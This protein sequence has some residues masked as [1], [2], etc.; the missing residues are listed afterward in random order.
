MDHPGQ[1][2]LGDASALIARALVELAEEREDVREALGVVLRWSQGRQPEGETGVPIQP[3]GEAQALVDKVI[4]PSAPP[5][6]SPLERREPPASVRQQRKVSLETIVRRAGWKAAAC[7]LAVDR[8]RT[9]GSKEEAQRLQKAEEEL[10]Q[11]R[12]TLEDCW[13]WMLDSPRPLPNDG[14]LLDVAD[15]YDT[16]ALAARTALELEEQ[17]LFDPKPPADLLHLLAEAQSALLSGLHRCELR[18]DND[19]RDLFLWLKDQTTRHRIYVD[20]HMRLDDPA[21]SAG[22]ESLRKR[23]R[24][25]ARQL[26]QAN[27]ARRSR[28]QLMNKVRYHLR[29]A[30]E[31]GPAAEHDWSAVQAA[32]GEWGRLGL[33]L[34]QTEFATLVRTFV[35]E[36]GAG[37]EPTA[38]MSLILGGN[39]DPQS[40]DAAPQSPPPETISQ[41][42]EL[43]AGRR[44]VLLGKGVR[45][46]GV[47]E[48]R[49]ALRLRELSWASMSDEEDHGARLAEVLGAQEDGLV[50]LATRLPVEEYAEFKRLCKENGRPFVRL[51]AGLEPPRVAHQILRQIGWRLRREPDVQH[52]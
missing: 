1:P 18:G 23:L 6:S 11:Q 27:L 38:E 16:V 35:T 3:A 37:R 50:L 26:S 20:R 5:E 9:R 51:P 33:S 25:L 45:P 36:H 22:S 34:E 43:L 32:C 10:R 28:V 8:R 14:L 19:Q 2:T 44:A 21:D 24:M 46:T 47:D 39:P 42:A 52:P 17:G 29:K 7:R 40:A 15:C 12:S 49:D 13:A 30:A 31:G 41:A 4:T 48:L